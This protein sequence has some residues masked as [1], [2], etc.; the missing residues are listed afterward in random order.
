MSSVA[1]LIPARSGSKSIKDKNLKLLSGY[2][3]LEWSIQAAKKSTLIDRVFLSTDSK[4]YA[5][6]GINCGAEVPF[7]RP[8][9]I[10]T[11]T[12]SDYEFV[13]HAINKF[14]EIEYSPKYIVHIRPTTPLRD[15]EIIDK[16]I[17]SFC[18]ESHYHSLRSVHEMSETSYKT[19]EIN[20]NVL[21][22]LSF[23]R[24]KNIDTNAPRQDFPIT[25]QANGYVD[26]LRK[27]RI[28]QKKELHGS[29]IMPFITNT[30]QEV[31]SM[32]DFEYLEYLTSKS[33][34]IF[35]K[36]FKD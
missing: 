16:A 12:S 32:E 28:I 19:F 31:D 5:K 14:S 24:N 2:S 23:L 1:A 35:T 18:K 21:T 8:K 6:I 27:D 4:E 33:N 26:V 30:A 25:Y 13:Y 34:N 29:K 9:N 10:S 20:D 15:P 22:P 36:L 3:L 11:D 7:I 17:S